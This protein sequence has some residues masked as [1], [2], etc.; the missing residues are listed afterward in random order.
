MSEN[1]REFDFARKNLI[2]L[3]RAYCSP[4]HLDTGALMFGPIKEIRK[5]KKV[6]VRKLE[7]A[8]NALLK[9]QNTYDQEILFINIPIEQLKFKIR[10]NQTMSIDTLER[11]SHIGIP[12][13]VAICALHMICRAKKGKFYD[14]LERYFSFENGKESGFELDKKS[15][16]AEQKLAKTT[17]YEENKDDGS[18]NEDIGESDIGFSHPLSWNIEGEND[19]KKRAKET[20]LRNLLG[21]HLGKSVKKIDKRFLP[22][23][24]ELNSKLSDVSAMDFRQTLIIIED[25]LPINFKKKI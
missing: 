6:K 23:I 1:S 24:K 12:R 19:W 22:K 18:E 17:W 25:F 8:L 9:I 15:I 21:L 16:L 13:D 5:I 4:I 10:W 14:E 3:V 7:S 2:R 20:L 11:H